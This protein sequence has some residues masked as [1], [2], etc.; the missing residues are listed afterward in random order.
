LTPGAE[1]DV[2]CSVAG[3][4]NILTAV[5]THGKG[6]VRYLNANHHGDNVTALAD[7]WGPRSWQDGAYAPFSSLVNSLLANKNDPGLMLP[8]ILHR[9]VFEMTQFDGYQDPFLPSSRQRA[10]SFISHYS[11]RKDIRSDPEAI[12]ASIIPTRNDFASMSQA[13]RYATCRAMTEVISVL[14]DFNVP[15]EVGDSKKAEHYVEYSLARMKEIIS[16]QRAGE[17]YE[18]YCEFVFQLVPG[19]VPI[20]SRRRTRT[21]EV[22]ILLSNESRHPLIRSFGETIPV[23]CKFR[24]EPVGAKELRDFAGKLDELGARSGFLVSDSGLS[25]PSDRN[26]QLLLRDIGMRGKSLVALNRDDLR[27]LSVYLEAEEIVR[28]ARDRALDL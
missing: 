17:V 19:L 20:Q 3:T 22:D 8:E 15:P 13:E 4:K 24:S 12:L 11:E 21:G 25:G 26:A 18:L 16:L 1:L 6:E 5:R 7:L 10:A 9:M 28:R 23:E 27:D 14:A 2:S